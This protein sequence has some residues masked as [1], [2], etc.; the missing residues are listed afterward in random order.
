MK[1]YA[2]TAIYTTNFQLD[3]GLDKE[4]IWLDLGKVHDMAEV[5]VNDVYCGSVWTYPDRVNV[6]EVVREGDNAL[7]V[8][9]VNGWANRIKGVHDKRITNGH[10]WTNARYWIEN[11]HL[12]TSGLL[13]PLT[14]VVSE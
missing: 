1:Y 10:I 11:Q 7:E 3:T 6:T 2:G 5:Y 9:V 4:D 12:Q 13:G 8:R 14:L